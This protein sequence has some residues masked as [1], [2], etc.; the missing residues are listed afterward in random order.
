M[1]DFGQPMGAESKLSQLKNE[2]AK[3]VVEFLDDLARRSKSEYIAGI[4]F[5]IDWGSET[6]TP[7]FGRPLTLMSLC[8]RLKHKLNHYMDSLTEDQK[9]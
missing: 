2:T 5:L 3:E 1:A 4:A 8:E 7:W 9:G 6:Q